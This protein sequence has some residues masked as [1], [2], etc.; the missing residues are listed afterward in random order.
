MA[1]RNFIGSCAQ[2]PGEE[3]IRDLQKLQAGLDE[4]ISQS[5]VRFFKHS[6]P[7]RA[8]ASQ[9][10]G[11]DDSDAEGAGGD[12]FSRMQMQPQ[13]DAQGRVRRKMVFAGDDAAAVE[14]ERDSDDEGSDN[15]DDSDGHAPLPTHASDSD[16]AVPVDSDGEGSDDQGTGI[17]QGSAADT[18]GA[19]GSGSD[20]ALASETGHKS[21]V[22]KDRLAARAE[23][24]FNSRGQSIM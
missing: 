1:L 4:K 11:S 18:E 16:E 14:L 19:E 12:V 2:G 10:E 8:P 20:E 6:A 23:K 21:G 24:Q 9:V 22:W 5:S 13:V 15:D 17:M 7:V 3:L